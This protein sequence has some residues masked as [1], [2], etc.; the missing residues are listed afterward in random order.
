MSGTS[1]IAPPAP[2]NR[3]KTGFRIILAIPAL[4]VSQILSY[5]VQVLA[6][7]S[8]FACLFTGAMPLGL[9]RLTAWIVR[10]NAQ[11]HGYVLLLTER[12]PDFSPDPPR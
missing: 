1:P 3:W 5:L 8:W 4:I 10:F 7:I 6:I 2:Q 9:L 11:T 12:Y